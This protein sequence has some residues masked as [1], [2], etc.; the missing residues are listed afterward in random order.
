MGLGMQE[1][2]HP[3]HRLAGRFEVLDASSAPEYL[4]IRFHLANVGDVPIRF[5]DGGRGANGR[6]RDDRFRFEIERDGRVVDGIEVA[7]FGGFAI[8][9]SLAPGEE[10]AFELDLADWCALG[11]P[12]EYCVRGGY[13]IEIQ[14]EELA[15]GRD[16]Y[17]T[18]AHESWDDV[19]EASF[20]VHVG[21]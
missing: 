12:G 19:V 2:R 18:H 21:G 20:V 14:S 13:E 3:G 6:E 1:R 4:P 16:P 9:R 7:S 8:S 17:P 11:A 10:Q 15:A 5:L